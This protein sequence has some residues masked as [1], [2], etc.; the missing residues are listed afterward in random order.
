MRLANVVQKALHEKD[1]EAMACL[2]GLEQ[3]CEKAPFL[4]TLYLSHRLLAPVLL[5]PSDTYRV[6]Q[7]I[8]SYEQAGVI[9]NLPQS[10]CKKQKYPPRA[11]VTLSLQ[12]ATAQNGFPS[13]FHFSPRITVEGMELTPEE[14]AALLAQTDP[15]VQIRG[16]WVEV[17]RE[18]LQRILAHWEQA[19][20]L[21][22]QGVGFSQAMRMLTRVRLTPKETSDAAE[23]EA[24]R[25]VRV[26]PSPKLARDLRLLLDPSRLPDPAGFS[27]LDTELRAH[28]RPYQKAGVKW[29]HFLYQLGI[30]GCLADDMGLGKTV[31]VLALLLLLRKERGS[32][33]P[34]L[35]IAPASLLPNWEAEAQK[36]APSLRIYVLHSYRNPKG[37]YEASPPQEE[38]SV[39]LYIMSYSTELPWVS[40]MAWSLVILDEAQAIKNPGAQ[41]T[42]RIKK[43]SAHCHL[44]LTGTPV[45]NSLLDLWSLMDFACPSLLATAPEFQGYVARLRETGSYGPLRAL[46]APYLL[47]RQ[48]TDP[49][50]LPDLPTKTEI[51][52]YCSLA[53]AQARLYQE[54]LLELTKELQQATAP[55]QRK[56][57]ILKYLLYF[58]QICNHP[59]L[60]LG[61]DSFDP[62]HSGKLQ[63]LQELAEIIRARGESLLVF[64]QFRKMTQVLRDFLTPIFDTPGFCLHGGTSLPHRKA[65]VEAFQAHESPTFFV[66]SLKAGGTGLTL[67]RASHVIHFDR[68]WNPAVETQATDRAFRM[69]Q[70]NPVLVH[71]FVCLG[72]LE[73]RI[74][75]MLESKKSLSQ[76]VIHLEGEEALLA[77][78]DEELLAWMKLGS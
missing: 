24:E 48:K 44:A 38:G 49:G 29:M 14:I 62:L 18:A 50:I 5:S 67:T 69:G 11:Q 42:A 76:E 64:T 68:W 12:D 35:L 23:L 65:Q 78:S 59:T 73:A 71:P 37:A 4:E 22:S 39:D 56:G 45:E 40:Q 6:L 17:N 46:L 58:K 70:K 26:E 75:A 28:L 19:C 9:V 15:L 2:A 72:T 61:E 77:L 27:I 32:T 1:P 74:D 7:E 36:F 16:Q 31:Q 47:R 10:W 51:K 20:Y 21:Q 41:Q 60:R 13:L 66:L 3:A 34:C 25:L 55:S 30:G 33:A 8:P 52:A 43:L 54:T 53:P 57:A 63:H